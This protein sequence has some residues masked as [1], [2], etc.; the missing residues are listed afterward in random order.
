MSDFEPARHTKMHEGMG[1][2]GHDEPAGDTYYQEM[3]VNRPITGYSKAPCIINVIF[4]RN[5]YLL[6]ARRRLKREVDEKAT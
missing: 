3:V 4:N 1:R 6:N 5:V 2:F